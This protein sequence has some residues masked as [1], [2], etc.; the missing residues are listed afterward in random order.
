MPLCFP[1]ISTF[2][3]GAFLA[4]V[5]SCST[6]DELKK[7]QYYAEGY[8]LYTTHCANCHQA[9]GQ[10]LANLYPPL[11]GSEYLADKERFICITRYGLSGEITVAGK[12]YNR[13]MP[14]NPQLKDLEIA[15]IA[16]YV[17]TT[18]GKDSTYTSTEMVTEVL[19]TCGE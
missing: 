13:P 17:Y 2:A 19:G 11:A 10:G 1:R 14:A 8:Q 9:E 4:L 7:D 3:A 12:T 5:L 6:A 18:W 15:E 16:T